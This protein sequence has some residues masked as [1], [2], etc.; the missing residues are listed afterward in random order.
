MTKATSPINYPLIGIVISEFNQDIT[1]KLYE[2]AMSRL[3]EFEFPEENLTVI[4]VP[5][6]VEIPITAKYLIENKKVDAVICLGAVIRGETTH[7][8][9]V[10]QQVSFGCQH[11]A[12]TYNIPVIFG[13]LT[14]ED[15]QQALA[16]ISKGRECVDG[17]L[18]MIS[19]LEKIK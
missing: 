13:V 18:Q 10:C 15:E 17:A 2:S 6:A 14:T 3:K 12:L 7:Y 4:W 19:V 16:R 5:G 9:Y 11:I 8:D 1:K